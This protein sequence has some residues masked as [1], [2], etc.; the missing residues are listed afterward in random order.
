MKKQV[1][2]L[3]ALRL[4]LEKEDRQR[5]S[6]LSAQMDLLADTVDRFYEVLGSRHWI[7]H[8]RLSITRLKDQV[9][10]EP[11]IDEAEIAMCRIYEDAELM[12]IMILPLMRFPEMRAR[13]TLVN[14]ALRDFT[15]KR[16]YATVLT[17]LTVMDGFVNDVQD[18]RRGLH[19]R[20]ATELQAWD[21]AVGHHMGLTATQASFR[22]SY[23]RRIDEEFFDLAR[24]GILHGNITN[25]DNVIVASKAWNRLFAVV[26]WASSLEKAAKPKDKEP[27]W[28]EVVER[29]RSNAEFKSKLDEWE[30]SSGTLKTTDACDTHTS[31]RAA[32]DFL[33]LWAKSN[34]GHLSTRFMRLGKG[35][36]GNATPKEIKSAFSP[37]VLESFVVRSYEVQAPAVAEVSVDIVVNGEMF[38]AVLRMTY[39]N[40]DGDT[41]VEGKQ[42]GSWKMVFRSPEVY[43]RDIVKV[44]KY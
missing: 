13:E 43:S 7:F 35:S 12:R 11:T 21:T 23:S 15:E 14:H 5:I 8:D 20:D 34:W 33:E 42:E 37:Y 17:L 44:A 38:P 31:T 40:E 28:G 25:Y 22:K 2:G 32:V 4:F 10:D 41:R 19:A 9:L 30:A 26:D 39:T 36:S 27:T 24:N 18:V 6:E 3:K 1:N 16:Y 29:I